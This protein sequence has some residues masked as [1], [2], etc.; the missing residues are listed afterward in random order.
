MFAMAQVLPGPRPGSVVVYSRRAELVLSAGH[1][2]SSCGERIEPFL[3]LSARRPDR[4][5]IVF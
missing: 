1:G 5:V 3:I 2:W 4:M